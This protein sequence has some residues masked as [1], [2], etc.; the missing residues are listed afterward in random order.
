VILGL[1]IKAEEIDKMIILRLLGR[2]DASSSSLLKDRLNHLIKEGHNVVLLDFSNIDYLSSA[3]LRLLL[4]YTKKY[5]E[6]KGRLGIFS[7]NDDVMEII[8][9]TGFDKILNIYKKEKEAFLEKN[10]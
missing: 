6:S 1:E 10:L 7:V 9:L 8:K 4:A 5:K 3:G 2:L